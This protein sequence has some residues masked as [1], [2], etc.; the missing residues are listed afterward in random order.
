MSL[1]CH[2]FTILVNIFFVLF[3]VRFLLVVVMLNRVK[4]MEPRS[5]DMEDLKILIKI[6]LLFSAYA[7]HQLSLGKRLA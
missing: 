4:K 7:Y 5:L 1:A 3:L 2:L 6:A